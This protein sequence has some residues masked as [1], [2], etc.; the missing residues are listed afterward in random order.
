MNNQL[1]HASNVARLLAREMAVEMKPDQVEAARDLYAAFLKSGIGVCAPN[2]EGLNLGVM[3]VALATLLGCCLEEFC[4]LTD[5]LRPM[6]DH[7]KLKKE[8]LM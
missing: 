2:P 4:I 5:P 1:R 3:I 6:E 8:Y 7:D